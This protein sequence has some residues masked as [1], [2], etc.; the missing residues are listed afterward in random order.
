MNQRDSIIVGWVKQAVGEMVGN[1]LG[2]H[3][4]EVLTLIH[5]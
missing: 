4:E 3:D 5:K 1:V 2:S